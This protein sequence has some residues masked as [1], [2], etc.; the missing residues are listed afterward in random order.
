MCAAI[1]SK[2]PIITNY[3]PVTSKARVKYYFI[4]V[5]FQYSYHEPTPCKLV[6]SLTAAVISESATCRLIVLSV[7]GSDADRKNVAHDQRSDG[8]KHTLSTAPNPAATPP[9][10]L[11]RPLVR[12][13]H[14]AS[15]FDTISPPCRH[16]HAPYTP[17][18]P[19]TSPART[20]P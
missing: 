13:S 15:K 18:S 10:S 5:L 19:T 14:P 7:R 1:F 8:I 11:S 17:S 9:S 12:S 2:L 6:P 3:E 16:R 20:W 4:F